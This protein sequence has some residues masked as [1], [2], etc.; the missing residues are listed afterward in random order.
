MPEDE[1]FVAQAAAILRLA[2]EIGRRAEPSTYPTVEA[3][4]AEQGVEVRAAVAD[5][6]RLNLLAAQMADYLG[7][8]RII[9][10]FEE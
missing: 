9:S 3:R 1:P 5:T 7:P 4:R 2:D 10:S 6:W 8:L